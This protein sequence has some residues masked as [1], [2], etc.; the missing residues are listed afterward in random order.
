MGFDDKERV[1]SI[2]TRCNGNVNQALDILLG[3]S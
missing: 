1:L 3:G 2:L